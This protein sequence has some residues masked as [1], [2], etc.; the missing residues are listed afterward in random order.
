MTFSKRVKSYLM[1]RIFGTFG[2]DNGINRDKWVESQLQAIPAG[3]RI[4]DAGAGQCKYKSLC[5]HLNYTSQDFNQYT[6][7]GDGHGFQTETWDTSQIDIVSDIVNIPRP[8]SSFDV[9]LCTEVFE[10]IFRPEAAVREFSRLLVPGG[11]LIL[12]A[13]FCSLTHFAPYHFSTGFN[14]YWYEQVL[15]ENNF[16]VEAITPNGNY[17]SYL[18]QEI[19]R[20]HS[21]GKIYSGVGIGIRGLIGAY[22]MLRRLKTMGMHDTCSSEV[23]CFGYHVI[24]RRS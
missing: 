24:A 16:I 6:G 15:S 20:I 3:Q 17:F 4:L 1:K 23:L 14:R 19:M 5:S 10:H 21:M 11:K 2:T 13:P 9:I 12:T 22:L 18:A 8:D 7:K